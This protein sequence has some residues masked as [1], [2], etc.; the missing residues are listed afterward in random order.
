MGTLI[1][2]SFVLSILVG[3]AGSYKT[4]GF[5]GAFLLSIFFTPVVGIIGVAISSRIPKKI[6]DYQAT[7]SDPLREAK[8]REAYYNLKRQKELGLINEQEFEMQKNQIF[9]TP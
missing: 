6:N 3:V 9:N 7:D 2:L 5:W 8:E 1:F 4:I